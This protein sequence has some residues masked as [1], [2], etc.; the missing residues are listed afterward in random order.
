MKLS[1]SMARRSQSDVFGETI[2]SPAVK[3]D[4]D[5]ERHRVTFP[6]FLLGESFDPNFKDSNLWLERYE[7]FLLNRGG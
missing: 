5:L 2:V 6:K 4:R 7:N 3:E 1:L